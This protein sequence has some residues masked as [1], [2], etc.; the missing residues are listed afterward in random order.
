MAGSD[1][2]YELVIGLEVHAQLLTKSK[3]FCGDSVAYGAA[4]NSQVS[5]V[6]LAHPGSLPVMNKAA[7]VGAIRMGLACG[8]EIERNNYF[9][10]KNYFYPDLPKGYQ[11]SQH[12]T[13]ICRQG[14][15][16][17]QTSSG[18]RMV[19]LNRIHMEEDAGKSIH[20]I[21]DNNTCIDYNRA[22]TGLIEIVT[23]PD[24]HSGEEVAAYLTELRKMLRYLDVC[25]GN[26]E[27][28]SMRC[29]V[30]I[31]VRP[32]GSQAL[33][34]KVE[35]KNLNSIRNARKAVESEGERLTSLLREGKPVLQQTRGFDVASGN[36]YAIRDKEDADDYRY[37]PD[38]DLP[39]FRLQEA[40]I[41]SIRAS[42]PSLQQE[43]I[44]IYKEKYQ[45]PEYDATVLTEDRAMA[46]Y[47]EQ[48]AELSASPKASANWM[49]G[50][51][52]SW[53][54]DAGTDIEKFPLAPQQ[55]AALIGMV[56]SQLL[57]F[58]TASSLLFPALLKNGQANV[59]T[60]AKEMNL[61]QQSDRSLLE[62]IVDEVL[63]RFADK[64][65]EYQKG[66]KG[67]LSLFVGEVMK[68][69][70]GKADPKVT[71]ALLLEKLQQ[72]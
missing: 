7:I 42:L 17:I 56:N 28:G 64:V 31:S 11:I 2:E 72:S 23:E 15:V 33:G 38:P 63:S 26:M 54:N 6:T 70:K 48:L 25:D 20:D 47:F 9:A 37:F 3:L 62:P 46:D 44:H 14:Q 24:L 68:R 43:R 71:N 5:P 30:N 69:S 18:E 65:K 40:F 16:R 45:L 13:P 39:P 32:R 12:T 58:S 1:I 10:R 8:C 19:R 49:L 67:V 53:L 41:E 50:P 59:E 34:T 22:G 60:L 51:V 21:S 35:I 4:P 29:D 27:E 36:S 55:L 57:S 66:K 61:L 52:K